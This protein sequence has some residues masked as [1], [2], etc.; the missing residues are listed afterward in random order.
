MPDW[1][2]KFIDT[3]SR[4]PASGEVRSYDLAVRLERGMS[5]QGGGPP[6]PPRTS[7]PGSRWAQSRRCRR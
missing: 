5:R 1:A 4:F 6:P 3:T 7:P 2:G